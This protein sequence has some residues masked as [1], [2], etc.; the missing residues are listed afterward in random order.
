MVKSRFHRLVV[1]GNDVKTKPIF[2]DVGVFC[3]GA[4][5][6][7]IG[8]N[9]LY[10]KGGD[11]L[12]SR[13]KELQCQRYCIKKK[14]SQTVVNYYDVTDLVIH[15]HSYVDTLISS[16]KKLA[17]RQYQA[18]NSFENKRLR[19]LPN[20]NVSLE[21]YLKKANIFSIKQLYE[22]GAEKAFVKIRALNGKGSDKR[23]LL[24]L[25]GAINSVQWQLIQ[26]PTINRLMDKVDELELESKSWR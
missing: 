21:R 2:G 18:Q 3:Q 23:V 14:N 25:Y 13:F 24:K 9:K 6:A 12:D 15:D 11:W 26:E 16:S 17:I 7:L 5:F 8:E 22:L 19:D 1:T 4:M 10:L 20:M